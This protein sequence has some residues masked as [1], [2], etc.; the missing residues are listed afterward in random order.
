MKKIKVTHFSYSDIYG[1]AARA[2]Y[3]LNKSLNH[4]QADKIQSQ[5]RVIRKGT[6]DKNI[7]QA[8]NRL[9]PYLSITKSKLSQYVHK[10]HQTSN[11][12]THS[13]AFF[14]CKLDI[15]INNSKNDIINLHWV[16][17]EMLSIEAIG[18]IKK[19]LVWTLHDTWAFCGSEHYFY[20]EDEKRNVEGYNS[21]NQT[22]KGFDF[23]KW[24]WERKK[25]NWNKNINIV[26]P[27]RWLLNC[28]K[29]S[30]LMSKFDTYLIP[31]PLPL[32]IYKPITKSFARKIYN[33]PNESKLILFGAST[34]FSL[35]KGWDFFLEIVTKISK[36]NPSF[37]FIVF[38]MDKPQVESFTNVKI[39]FLGSIID[40]YALSTL[41]SSCDVMVLPSRIENLPQCATEAQACGLPVAAFDCGGISDVVHN[42]ITGY[43]AKPFE[44]DQ[45]VKGIIWILENEERYEK[46]STNS[47]KTAQRKWN[48][49]EIT[50]QYLNLYESIL[51]N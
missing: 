29:K 49:K 34:P 11:P 30:N 32:D 26:C 50:K 20:G 43:L 39:K 42:E 5:M 15:E 19:P 23:D 14:P 25:K 37:E 2:A 36:I 41:Y 22:N 27:S 24:C 6:V 4:V 33:L 17:C 51:E 9:S 48:L 46:L 18:R 7:K 31:N 13:Y 40:E 3:R 21:S 47:F 16:Q 10:F 1:G 12:Y 45:I 28:V 8:T 35:R 38:G 44:I